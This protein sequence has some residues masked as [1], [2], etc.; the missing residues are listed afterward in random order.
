MHLW[1]KAENKNNKKYEKIDSD[2]FH[3]IHDIFVVC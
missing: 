3:D 2:S 1:A